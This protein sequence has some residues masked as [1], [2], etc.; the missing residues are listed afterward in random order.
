MVDRQG[1]QPFKSLCSCNEFQL[2]LHIYAPSS[3]EK[4]QLECCSLSQ[5]TVKSLAVRCLLFCVSGT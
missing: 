4:L 2:Q 5:T 3:A 1:S